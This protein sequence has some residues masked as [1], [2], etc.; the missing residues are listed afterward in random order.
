MGD[1]SKLRHQ[2]IIR[3]SSSDIKTHAWLPSER[4]DRDGYTQEQNEKLNDLT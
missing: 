2:R 4:T 3:K 1:K